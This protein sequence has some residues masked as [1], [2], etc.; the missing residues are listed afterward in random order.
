MRFWPLMTTFLLAVSSPVFGQEREWNLD[1]TDQDAFLVFGT[2]ETDDVGLSFWCK[3]SSTTIK[4]YVPHTNLALKE[5][6]KTRVKLDISGKHFDFT[7]SPALDETTTKA[8][9]VKIDVEDRV[10]S[11]LINADH[12]SIRIGKKEMNF[13]LLDAD[14]EGLIKICRPSS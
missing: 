2:P 9:E 10:F 7:G 6:Q 1:V 14:I 12:L 3:L 8:I 4:L 5:G 11:Q 13:P